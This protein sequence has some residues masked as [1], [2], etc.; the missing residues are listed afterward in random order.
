MAL[1]DYD[2]TLVPV[3]S[4]GNVVDKVGRVGWWEFRPDGKFVN[5]AT[6][7]VHDP[8]NIG[9]GSSYSDEN[10]QDAVGQNFDP[11]LSYDDSA[12]EFGVANSGIDTAQ[13]AS[14]AVTEAKIAAGAVGSNELVSEAVRD[15]AGGMAGAYLTHDDANDVI[16]TD[17][18]KWLVDHPERPPITELGDTQSVEIPILVPNGSTLEV[19]LW[20]AFDVSDGSS[21]TGLTAE[22][23]D[24]A[25]TVQASESTANNQDASTPVA[26]HS[27][28]SGSQS[29]F[30]LRAYNGTGAAINSP[31]VGCAF[32]YRVV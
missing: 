27:N 3:D 22:L 24:G 14:N 8:E 13:I 1:E 31:G 18:P 12:P 5:L 7:N 4:D 9:G 30:K 20:G 32:G 21:P 6:G 15:I 28:S 11:T 16:D 23:L 29:V 26:S 2:W 10:A 25:D 19:F 17:E